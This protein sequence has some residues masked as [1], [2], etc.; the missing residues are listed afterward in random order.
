MHIGK[1]G[2]H[3]DFEERGKKANEELLWIYWVIT[4]TDGLYDSE[5]RQLQK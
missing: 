3:R 2:I 1:Y 5:E 4:S